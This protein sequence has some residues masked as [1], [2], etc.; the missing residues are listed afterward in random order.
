MV[1]I[2]WSE[3]I[4]EAVKQAQAYMREYNEA[5]TLRGIYYRLVSVE[6]IP[7]TKPSLN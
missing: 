6:A 1:S 5:P 2:K 3:V 4:P 7:N